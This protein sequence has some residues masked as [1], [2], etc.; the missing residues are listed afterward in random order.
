MEGDLLVKL[1]KVD[2]VVKLPLMLGVHLK[3]SSPFE[4]AKNEEFLELRPHWQARYRTYISS[5][6]HVP[7]MSNNT[8]TFS[9]ISILIQRQ[10][11]QVR[12][13]FCKWLHTT[14][15]VLPKSDFGSFSQHKS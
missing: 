8:P 2:F 14:L 10:G 13:F 6:A 9:H 1:R 12:E 5:K 3:L 4:G 15:I 7:R 11:E